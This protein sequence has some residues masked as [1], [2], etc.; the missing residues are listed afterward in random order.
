MGLDMYL[1]RRT[2]VKHWEYKGNDNV[3]VSVT[4]HG[5]P[6]QNIDPMRVSYIVEDV[7]YWRKANWIHKWFVDNVQGGDDNCGEYSVEPSQLEELM[8][9]CKQVIDTA[10][11]TDGKIADP[12]D[13]QDILPTESGC[14]FGSEEYDQ[15]YIDE[16]ERTYYAL[17][18]LIS[19]G[20][21]LYYYHSSW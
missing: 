3:Q 20:A 2:Y 7:M 10:I 4:L 11:G 16:T 9:L 17:R 18:E 15:W 1:T 5:K 6:Y 13:F 21:E 8:N 14:F 19:E 12:E